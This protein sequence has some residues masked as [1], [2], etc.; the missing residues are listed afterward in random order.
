MANMKK[1]FDERTKHRVVGVIVALALMIIFLPAMMRESDKNFPVMPKVTLMEPKA[2][3]RSVQATPVKLPNLSAPK[4]LDIAEAQPLSQTVSPDESMQAAQEIL[5]KLQVA[6]RKSMKFNEVFTIQ[7]AS[8]TQE[9]NA[10]SLVNKLRL[11]GF[12][13][14]K[15]VYQVIV[16]HVKQ[17]DQAIDLQKK[18]VDNTR[19]NGLII[20]TKV[21]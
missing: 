7:L 6:E 1:I 14:S 16:G 10:Q 9:A 12:A 8:F 17:R 20:K 18:L 11:Q 15:Q 4:H 19:L 2:M 13:A 5:K 3:L 21:I